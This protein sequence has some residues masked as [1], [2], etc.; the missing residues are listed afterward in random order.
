[1]NYMMREEMEE[2][3]SDNIKKR[4]LLHHRSKDQA[5]FCRYLSDSFLAIC[6]SLYQ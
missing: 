3:H 2:L 4:W 5:K 1:M 6:T